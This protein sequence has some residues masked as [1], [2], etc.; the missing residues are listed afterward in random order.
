M[1]YISKVNPSSR[2]TAKYSFIHGSYWMAFGATYNFV[3]VYLL[4]KNYSSSAIGIIMAITNILSAIL[5]PVVASYADQGKKYTLKSLMMI[6]LSLSTSFSILL[7]F[8]KASNSINAF[9]YFLLL[10]SMLTVHPLLNGLGMKY[11]EKGY[12]INF[13]FS[14]SMGSLTY[15]VM[16]VVLGNLVDKNGPELLPLY[17]F[18]LFFITTAAT[19]LFLRSFPYPNDETAEEPKNQRVK[20]SLSLLEFTK[21]YSGFTLYLV[22]VIFIFICFNIINIYM[23]R[24]IES[25]GGSEKNMGTA[26]AIAA[27]V[28]LPFMLTFSSLLR[29]FKIETLLIVSAWAFTAKVLL[30]FFAES[31]LVIYIAQGFQMFSYALFIPGSIYYVTTSLHKS[32]MLKGQAYTTSATTVGAVLGSL[33]G[34][35]LLSFTTIR[36]MLAVGFIVSIIGTL[37]MILGIRKATLCS[38]EKLM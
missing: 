2:I 4:A 38:Q 32:H 25:V 37:L 21:M 8:T 15:A 31:L 34:G 12:G 17:Y 14:R 18:V 19:V 24:I 23:I 27:I 9:V 35:Y 11:I 33:I 30:T 6:F 26:F 36:T 3:T 16:S 1:K 7:Y 28:E 20:Q 22:G 5:Q 13:G 10:L 29:K